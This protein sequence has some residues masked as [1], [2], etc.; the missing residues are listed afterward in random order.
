MKTFFDPIYGCITI[1][2]LLLRFID[3]P[4]FQRLR[5]LRQLSTV[6]YVFPSAN[7]TRFEHSIGVCH[8]ARILMSNLREKQPDLCISVRDIELTCLAGLL[9]D[10]GHGPYSHLYD[11]SVRDSKEPTHEERGIICIRNMVQKYN[12]PI[13]DDELDIVLDMIHP[14]EDK[15]E[16]WKYQIIA[17]KKYTIDV[18]KM[19]YIKRDCYHIGIQLGGDYKRIMNECLVHEYKG[20]YVLAWN[21]KV[22]FDLESLLTARFRLHKQVLTHHAV[23]A[24]EYM[25]LHIMNDM[26]KKGE[27][28]CILSDALVLQKDNWKWKNMMDNRTIYHMIREKR[29]VNGQRMEPVIKN[30]YVIDC[31]EIGYTS[32]VFP[33]RLPLYDKYHTV[34]LDPIFDAS[35]K[36]EI[37]YRLYMLPSLRDHYVEEAYSVWDT[38]MLSLS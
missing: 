11:H 2:P 3:T 15:Q 14:P 32:D 5:D 37:I 6:H 21:K 20:N 29:V 28:L 12:I 18:D 33:I 19:D 23:K 27:D 8:L 24:Y 1:S 4:E 26:K 38:L 13:N 17:N 7:H 31:I 36:C 22:E 30:G 25:I 9:H 10:I 35:K 34:S 16:S